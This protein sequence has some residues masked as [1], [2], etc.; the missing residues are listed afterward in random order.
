MEKLLSRRELLAGFTTRF[1]D[2]YGRT[3]EDA[4]SSD[5]SVA[6]PAGQALA[7]DVLK[8]GGNGLLYPSARHEKGQ[9]LV[10]LRPR[11]VQNVRQGETWVFEWAGERAPSIRK[12]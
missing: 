5:P 10:A 11:L 1:H 7:H 8:S 9:C 3:E 6:Y 12:A 4:L 2:L